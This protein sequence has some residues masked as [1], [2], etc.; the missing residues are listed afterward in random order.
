MDRFRNWTNRFIGFCLLK[1]QFR[2]FALF[3]SDLGHSESEFHSIFF[4]LDFGLYE[5]GSDK[6]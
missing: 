2:Y 6:F 1:K 5:E 4:F 3:V